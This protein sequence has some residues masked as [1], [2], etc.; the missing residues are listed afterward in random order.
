MKYVKFTSS[1][2]EK[3]D[4]GSKIIFKYPSP[5]VDFDIGRMVIN[6]RHPE[7]PNTF[8]VEDACSFVIYVISGAGKVYVDDE[9]FEVTAQDVIFVPNKT[10]FAVE[11]VFEYITF[12]SPGYYP[13]QSNEIVFGSALK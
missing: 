7:Y 2:T 3:I 12:D 11:G 9:T 8:L 1:D 6:G 13:E 10:R 4:L 5:T